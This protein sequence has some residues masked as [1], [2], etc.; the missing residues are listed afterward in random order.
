M[1]EIHSLCSEMES[2]IK[3]TSWILEEGD[4]RNLSFSPF[5]LSFGDRCVHNVSLDSSSLTERF[6]SKWDLSC[7]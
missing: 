5:T 1:K 6:C 7:F 3:W 2:G 4:E